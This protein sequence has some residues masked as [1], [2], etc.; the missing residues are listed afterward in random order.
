MYSTVKGV[1]LW[2]GDV[3]D[4]VSLFNYN[5]SRAGEFDALHQGFLVISVVKQSTHFIATKLLH[6]LF[7]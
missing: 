3:Y 7:I 2:V 4:Y 6:K 1:T 5:R